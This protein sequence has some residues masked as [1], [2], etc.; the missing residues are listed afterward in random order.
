VQVVLSTALICFALAVTL[1]ALLKS[2]G[3]MWDNI[4][5]AAS[6]TIFFALLCF[7]GLLEGTQIAAFEIMK[8]PEKEVAQ[9]GVAAINCKLLFSGR[10]FQAFL[11]GRQILVACLMFVVA[12]IV[13]I[14][15][16]VETEHIFSVGNGFQKFLNSGL[17]GAV[18]LTI[19]GSLAWR[20]VASSFPLAFM[21]NPIVYLIIRICLLLEATGI[22]SSAFL[23]AM[24]HRTIVNYQPDEVYIG[25]LN[26]DLPKPTK[27][28][29]RGESF[30]MSIQRFHAEEEDEDDIEMNGE[31]AAC[32]QNIPPARSTTP[33]LRGRRTP[34]HLTLG[35][36]IRRLNTREVCE[37]DADDD[38]ENTI[39][40]PVIQPGLRFPRKDEHT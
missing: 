27:R 35:Q 21:S 12:N 25:N 11:V 7:I 20:I 5:P 23:L 18:V 15:I 1:E 24:I 4:P 30:G 6:I 2:Q 33:A 29:S 9:H 17:L 22:C 3:G 32:I 14:R 36:T 37:H 38:D 16:D 13:T 40:H 31:T 34:E 28:T 10:H 26:N 39:S 19:V 8:M